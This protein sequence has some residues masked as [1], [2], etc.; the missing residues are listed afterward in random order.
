[1]AWT[2]EALSDS[3]VDTVI[4]NVQ[5][6]LNSISNEHGATVASAA[7]VAISDQKEGDA[8]GVIFFDPSVE[9][10]EPPE[11]MPS[12]GRQTSKT[13]TNYTR[14]YNEIADKLNSLESQEAFWAQVGFTNRR[15]GDATITVYW[16]QL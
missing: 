13:E 6:E 4:R 12:F 3:S 15:R 11:G 14:I 16:P 9:T 10:A 1:M 7:K 2:F 8:R 5:T